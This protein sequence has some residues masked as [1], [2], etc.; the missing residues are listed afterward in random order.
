MEF[1]KL[2]WYRKNWVSLWRWERR[3]VMPE[4]YVNLD[5]EAIERRK[6]LFLT[7]ALAR[8]IAESHYMS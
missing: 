1:Y 2:F 3:L 5:K 4:F 8:T 6:N 7:T